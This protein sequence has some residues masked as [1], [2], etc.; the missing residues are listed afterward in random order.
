[1]AYRVLSLA[2]FFYFPLIFIQPKS[3]FSISTTPRINM[4]QRYFF[5]TTYNFQ[6]SIQ[7][8]Y[9]RNL[10]LLDW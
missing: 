2:M 8:L 3:L 1:M 5:Q 7:N 10:T 9:K 6:K 4:L